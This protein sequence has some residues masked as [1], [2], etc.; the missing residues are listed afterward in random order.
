M[1]RIGTPEDITKVIGWPD[2]LKASNKVEMIVRYV[3]MNDIKEKNFEVA[4]N[5]PILNSLER[6][7]GLKLAI[8]SGCRSGACALC[9]T[10]LISGKV[11]VPPE[12][13]IREVDKKFGYIHP[14]ISYPL[15]NITIDLT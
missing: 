15:T 9:R 11:F 12:I 14:C 7:I 1:E 13:N 5:E 4:C 8:E 2:N 3:E 10:K 6:N